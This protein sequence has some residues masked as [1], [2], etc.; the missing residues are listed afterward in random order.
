AYH[1]PEVIQHLLT[2]VGGL[3]FPADK[4]EVKLLLEADDDETI[5]AATSVELGIAVDVVLVPPADP[6]TKPKA[7]NYGL[8][9]AT[10]DIIT[11]YDAEDVPDPLQ[12]RRAAVVLA[13]HGDQVACVQAQLSYSN[14]RQN[15]ITSWFTLEYAVGFALFLP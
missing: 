7:L 10:G 8:Q 5:S 15:I 11:I 6:R 4:L 1:E 12:L 13:R 9:L 14:D 3:E 2:A